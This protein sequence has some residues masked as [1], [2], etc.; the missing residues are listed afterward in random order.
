[1]VATRHGTNTDPP[2]LPQKELGPDVVDP[3]FNDQISMTSNEYGAI[4]A[5]D[6]S[7]GPRNYEIDDVLTEEML[8]RVAYP[9]PSI[10]FSPGRGGGSKMK[11]KAPNGEFF[12]VADLLKAV[13]KFG[14][15]G[16]RGEFD[17]YCDHCF[18]E[19]LHRVAPSTYEVCYG[20]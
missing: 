12:T 3:F 17:Y 6:F 7:E 4:A 11:F 2:E 20:S 18:Y 10:F 13:A 15:T 5:G 9:R 16:I 1:M 14:T 8:S 19:G